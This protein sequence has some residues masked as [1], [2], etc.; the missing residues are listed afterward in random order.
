LSSLDDVTFEDKPS[1][2]I[3]DVFKKKAE[4]YEVPEAKFFF[5]HEDPEV[6]DL[7]IACVSS[8][9]E[10]SPNWNDDKRK[11]HVKLELEHL[12]KLT[13]QAVYRI[14][15]RK[16]E[17]EMHKIREELKKE[18]TPED[19]EILLAKYQKLKEAES[20]LGGFLGSIVVK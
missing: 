5:S 17:R 11:I 12:Q 10:L 19:L 8:P 20:L 14:K 7:A 6:Q 1:A 16:F 18:Q 4:E 2:F 3:V 15:K 9:Y 13:I